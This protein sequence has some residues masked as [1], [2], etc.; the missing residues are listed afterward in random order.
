[1]KPTKRKPLLAHA[2]SGPAL[3][4]TLH[5]VLS[6]RE[7]TILSLRFGLDGKTP[8][9]LAAIGKKF[10]ITRERVRQ[11]QNRALSKTK[12]ALDFQPNPLKAPSH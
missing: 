12:R 7:Q 9:T 4:E 6:D 5:R 1:M 3:P 11:L 10:H 8:M 2:F